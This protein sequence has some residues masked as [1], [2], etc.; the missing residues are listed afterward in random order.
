MAST[1][2]PACTPALKIPFLKV[3]YGHGVYTAI[4]TYNNKTK[5]SAICF[6]FC[7]F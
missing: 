2:A 6:I 3:L 5:L 1:S 4:E 7:G